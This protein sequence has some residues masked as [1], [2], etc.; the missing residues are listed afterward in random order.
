M[1]DVADRLRAA[2]ADRYRIERALG[3]GG[4]ATVYLAADL[5]HDRKVALKVLKPELAA[6]LGADR[7]IQEIKT[8][9]SLQHPH[10]LPLFDSGEADGFLFYVMPYIDGETL[11]DRL[12]REAQLGI[13][14]AVRITCEVADALDYA[15][16]HGVI[17][18]DIKPENILLH[19]GRALVADFGIALAVSAAAGGRMTETGLSLGTP[20]YMSPE[21]A[22]AAKDL[23]GRSDIY[24][25]GAVLYEMLTGD[26]PHTGSTVQQII[27]K[28]V[29]EE[30]EPVTSARKTVPPNVAAATATALEKLPADRFETAA[31]FA[32]ALRDSDFS[33][34]ASGAAAGTTVTHAGRLPRL[35]WAMALPLVVGGAIIG[36][37]ARPLPDVATPVTRFTIPVP[38]GH[39]IR[40]FRPNLALSPDG[41]SVAYVSGN[42]LYLRRF[43]RPDADV[44]GD[45]HSAAEPQF[46]ADGRWVY[47]NTTGLGLGGI[48]VGGGPMVDF[49]RRPLDQAV[50][51]GSFAGPIMIRHPGD[52]TWV[53]LTA[54]ASN[55]SEGTHTRPQLLNDGRLLLYTVLG[56]GMMWSGARIVLED[57]ESGERTTLVT[58][59]SYGRYVPPGHVV[60]ITEDGTLEAVPVDLGRRRVTGP[61]V[62]VETGV[63]T[64]YWGGAASFAVSDAGTLAFVRGSSWEL[65]RLTWL[66]RVGAVLEY[67]GSP[68]TVEGIRLSPDERYGVTYVAS[69]KADIAR[70]DLRTGEQ[71]RLTFDEATEDNPV[72]SPDGRR[73]AYRR[74][75][76]GDDHRIVIA[77]LDGGGERLD[78]E[79]FSK[80]VIPRAWS[81]DGTAIAAGRGDHLLV[82]Q[83]DGSAVDTVTGTFVESATFSPDGRWLVYD[84]RETGRSEIYAV[85]YPSRAAKYQIS[86]NGGRMPLWT[87]RSSEV[88]FLNAD[89]MMVSVIS[90]TGELDWSTPRRLF[91]LEDLGD[92]LHGF[93]VTADGRRILV[94]TGNPDAV[95]TEIHV[96]LNWFEELKAEGK[97]AGR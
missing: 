36:W 9:A 18:R 30:A 26:P 84:S 38:G 62:T 56:P 60:Y 67:V 65:H 50:V 94:P 73:V 45:V 10:I 64:A 21:Q 42:T 6:V 23:T 20:H 86:T 85:S 39:R 91:Q 29:T 87:A 17:H 24:S 58:E 95:A 53:P 69:P 25:L 28:I 27:M 34:V 92:L 11:R 57:L 15:H 41:R 49:S 31:T 37:L 78:V 54:L 16:R 81:P 4:M 14:E 97:A 93:G 70:F 83:V 40:D 63:R 76:S 71:R 22:T 66:D 35:V 74:V 75:V 77:P 33:V 7:F 44:L 46:S 96:V 47:F 43:E 1:T 55:G 12:D 82:M 88:F 61:P 48:S 90:S 51:F 2:L 32:A 3:A 19:D 79:S 13:D 72:W 52:T 68:V 59:G 8:T 89:T 80:A 5:R